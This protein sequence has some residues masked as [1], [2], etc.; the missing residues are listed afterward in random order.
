MIRGRS[1]PVVNGQSCFVFT[2]LP[3][4]RLSR[5]AAT[6]HPTKST[7][8]GFTLIEVLLVLVLLVVIGALAAPIL[9]GALSRSQLRN[10][11]DIVQAALTRT[12]L[13]A[14]ESGQTQVFRCEMKGRRF[15]AGSMA[16]LASAGGVPVGP[17]VDEG[18]HTGRLDVTRLPSG[19]TFGAGQFAPSQQLAAFLGQTSDATWSN[20]IVFSPDGTCTDATLLLVNETKQT[21]RVTLRGVT[22]T[23]TVGEVDMEDVQ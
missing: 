5:R 22:G 9:T 4:R 14:M 11:G 19:V 3:R 21:I 7:G 20:P 17:D 12:R 23:A 8:R 13:T 16:E 10:G 15:Q 2:P 1:Q 6:C 18:P